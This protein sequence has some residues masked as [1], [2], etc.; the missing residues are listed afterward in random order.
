[1]SDQQD[2]RRQER[3][4]ASAVARVL[5]DSDAMRVGVEAELHDVSTEGIGIVIAEP[6]EL[7]ETVGVR[8][9]NY[10]QK[11]D[12]NTRGVVRHVTAREQGG[13]YVGIELLVRLPP[14][15]VSLLRMGI[16]DVADDRPETN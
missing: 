10:I 13:Y 3:H 2:R 7:R 9:M 8:L 12:V 11:V 14:L 15:S 1:M 16:R 6:P 5:R 4:R